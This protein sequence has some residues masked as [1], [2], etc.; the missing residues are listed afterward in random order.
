M[1][2]QKKSIS[3]EI[4]VSVWQR[5]T[6]YV[7]TATPAMRTFVQL[8]DYGY[9]YNNTGQEENMLVWYWYEHRYNSIHMQGVNR[10]DKAII[11]ADHFMLDIIKYIV[12]IFRL[13]LMIFG[14]F[15]SITQHVIT[16]ILF[17]Y[18]WFT[19]SV[20]LLKSC[21]CLNIRAYR[22]CFSE[23]PDYVLKMK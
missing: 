17:I 1:V 21:S 7:D 12:Y 13:D 22:L 20:G 15:R 5:S 11:V 6:T 19:T 9:R 2:S 18:L 4:C 16:G 23:R 8:N 10:N 14:N 3:S